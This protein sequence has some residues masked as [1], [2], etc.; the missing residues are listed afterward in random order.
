MK[1]APLFW[2]WHKIKENYPTFQTTEVTWCGSVFGNLWWKNM[3]KFCLEKLLSTCPSYQLFIALPLRKQRLSQ[4]ASI[5]WLSLR[6]WR[7]TSHHFGFRNVTAMCC[8]KYET[9]ELRDAGTACFT[10]NKKKTVLRQAF[11]TL[12]LRNPC[13]KRAWVSLCGQNLP[14]HAL[15]VLVVILWAGRWNSLT[16]PRAITHLGAGLGRWG[17]LVGGGGAWP[18][19]WSCLRHCDWWS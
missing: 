7:V 6:L 3:P 5:A 4:A 8:M 9:L 13:L 12:L 15:P 10:V 11:V 16:G 19:P 18:R 2:I 17:Q 1:I 14:S